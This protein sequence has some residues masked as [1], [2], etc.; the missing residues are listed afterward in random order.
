MILPSTNNNILCSFMQDLL[1]V[2][3][4]SFFLLFAL[5]SRP[6]SYDHTA[7][8]YLGLHLSFL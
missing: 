2:N 4:N 8:S 6:K 5:L 7:L 3:E 1:G